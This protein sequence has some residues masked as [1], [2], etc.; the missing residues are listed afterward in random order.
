MD[1]P[2]KLNMAD[3]N[4]ILYI[5]LVGP[6]EGKKRTN[7]REEIF[8][9][10]KDG[11]KWYSENSQMAFTFYKKDDREYAELAAEIQSDQMQIYFHR[12]GEDYTSPKE[13]VRFQIFEP[14]PMDVVA[15]DQAAENDIPMGLMA[16]MENL[17]LNREEPDLPMLRANRLLYINVADSEKY[18]DEE[19]SVI[20]EALRG[21][22]MDIP[23]ESDLKSSPY[24]FYKVNDSQTLAQLADQVHAAINTMSDTLGEEFKGRTVDFDFNIFVPMCRAEEPAVGNEGNERPAVENNGNER[25]AVE[26][27]GN[28][29]P[30]D[31]NDGD[32]GP[33]V[34]EEGKEEP[35]YRDVKPEGLIMKDVKKEELT[36]SDT[37]TKEP[38]TSGAITNFA[39]EIDKPEIK[40]KQELNDE[41]AQ[42]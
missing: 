12:D 30:A 19:L 5:D 39:D 3:A 31:Q 41:E 25:P 32:D 7:V 20:R 6:L 28:E 33:P 35:T 37:E 29:E 24:L 1:P 10:V 26:N 2:K 4:R 38:T 18:S 11:L 16:G 36:D 13:H 15:V 14:M 34:E 40:P 27:D 21:I 9:F 42:K 22:I 23:W 8:K 17:R